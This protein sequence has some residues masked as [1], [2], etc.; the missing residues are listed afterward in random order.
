[1]REVV[2][3][4][5]AS[6]GIAGDRLDLRGRVATQASHLGTYGEID[7]ALDP[8][9]YNGTTTTCEA[10]WMGVPLVSL[11]GDRHASRVGASLLA[12]A[13]MPQLIAEDADAFVAIAASL[14]RDPERR[15]ALRGSMRDRV[16]SSPLRDGV[17][18]ARAVESAYRAAWAGW[19]AEGKR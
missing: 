12:A 9:H 15:A 3:R 1:M 14:A 10:M 8:A 5:F 13:G 17:G 7:I 11:R 18:L 19:C 4:R 6:R 16:A 2:Q